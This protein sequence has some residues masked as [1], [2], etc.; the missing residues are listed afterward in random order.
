MN[1]GPWS[2][3]AGA[4]CCTQP[5]A[6]AYDR[7][8]WVIDDDG[9]WLSAVRAPDLANVEVAVQAGSL[10]LRAPGM[11]RLDIPL[12]VIEDD[13]SVCFK[14]QIGSQTV[15]VVDEGELAAAWM[16]NV[17]RRRCALMKI[18]PDARVPDDSGLS[19]SALEALGAK[20]PTA[21]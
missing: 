4:G 11:L 3:L 16:S 6:A 1:A 10:V 15:E 21:G 14:A 2:P 17:L 20:Q 8:W 19:E 9:I 7:R 5:E 12:D 13:D 18:H